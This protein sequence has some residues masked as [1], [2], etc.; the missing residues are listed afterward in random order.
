MKWRWFQ[1]ITTDE[2]NS[3]RT[4]MRTNQVA[5]QLL[6]IPSWRY[7]V[8]GALI[9]TFAR[10]L[11]YCLRHPHCQ[12]R[13]QDD[14]AL[15]VYLYF[16]PTCA[17]AIRP[18]AK[19]CP[20][21]VVGF[22]G[23]ASV[24]FPM[25]KML[26]ATLMAFRSALLWRWISADVRWRPWLSDVIFYILVSRWAAVRFKNIPPRTIIF[27]SDHCCFDRGI[28]D[29]AGKLGH[30]TV[31][32]QHAP[33]S[34][35]FPPLSAHYSL[36]D[37]VHALDIYEKIEGSR[38][39]AII[40][41]RQYDIVAIRHRRHD[42]RSAL[43]CTST[44]DSLEA[45]RPVIAT[46]QAAGYHVALRTHPA[47]R[48]KKAWR[49]LAAHMSLT[50]LD[51]RNVSVQEALAKNTLV[52]AGQSGVLLEA[53]LSGAKAILIQFPDDTERGLYD[54]YGLSR[55]GLAALVHPAEMK[56]FMEQLNDETE[57]SSLAGAIHYDAA[58]AMSENMQ[59]K[60]LSTIIEKDIV[61]DT[62]LKAGFECMP[63]KQQADLSIYMPVSLV[64]TMTL[65]NANA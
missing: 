57:V 21:D 42:S 61:E 38:G 33:V 46:V 65:A 37:G 54:Y 24:N 43:I 58:Y 7:T 63:S 26:L 11:V 53:A 49:K 41:G 22:S 2:L 51:T 62:L 47:D 28:A 40:C 10:N 50:W 13:L 5:G 4:S 48:Q 27:S 59:I 14:V 44:V 60:A 3:A 36:L 52:L 19:A 64:S 9:Y 29:T 34:H 16:T 45:W 17:N 20:G 56:S 32:V 6:P 31:Y 30:R 23:P 55:Q 8:I 1:P 35:I 39:A 15:P 18:L 25:W 12:N